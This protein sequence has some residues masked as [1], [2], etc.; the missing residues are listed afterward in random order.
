MSE[1]VKQLTRELTDKYHVT[2]LPVNCEQLK[3]EDI[4]LIL[5]NILYEFPVSSIEFYLPKWVSMLPE[6]NQIRQELITVA[7]NMLPDYDV[8]RDVFEKPVVLDS[9]YILKSKTDQVRLSD[10]VVCVTLEMDNAYYYAMLTQMIGEDI[11][12][13]NLMP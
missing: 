9:A 13:S 8:I 3:K 7:K 5:E 12:I 4:H 6:E 1:E 10:G 11:S 2:V